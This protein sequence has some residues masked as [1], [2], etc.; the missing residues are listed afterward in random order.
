[1]AGSSPTKTKL[2]GRFFVLSGRKDLPRTALPLARPRGRAFLMGGIFKVL[3]WLGGA[4]GV[5]VFVLAAAFGVLQT[6]V[7]KAWL[8][9]EIAQA[10]S[11]P[12]F[13]VAIDGLKGFVPFHMT[14]ER[15]DIGD[16]DG[17]Y[18]TLREA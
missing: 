13:T 7:G 2:L 1:M 9:N 15:I 18:L 5:L 3:R 17:A 4:L 11:D 16:R 8:E 10:I 12:D 6:R 14:V